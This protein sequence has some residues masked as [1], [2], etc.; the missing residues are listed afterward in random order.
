MCMFRG[1]FDCRMPNIHDGDKWRRGDRL[2]NEEMPFRAIMHASSRS[3]KNLEAAA[4]VAVLRKTSHDIQGSSINEV[5][6][7]TREA[8][9]HPL[10]GDMSTRKVLGRLYIEQTMESFQCSSRG[11]LEAE[12]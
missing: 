9:G 7:M 5:R 3:I 2:Y 1:P 4:T 11:T 10:T 8:H 12:K 6:R